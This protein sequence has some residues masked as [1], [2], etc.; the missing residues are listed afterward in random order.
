MR[1]H[2]RLKCQGA[3]VGGNHRG[4]LFQSEVHW[5]F[6]TS[7]HADL[8]HSPRIE[9]GQTLDEPDDRAPKVSTRDPHERPGELKAVRIRKVI[10]DVLR[11]LGIRGVGNRRLWKRWLLEKEI[12]RHEKQFGEKL[13]SICGHP[14]RTVFVSLNEPQGNPERVGDVGLRHLKPDPSLPKA[15]PDEA[16]DRIDST[17]MQML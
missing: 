5:R 12:D 8:R 7:D 4:E 2:R 10:K 16:V 3:K 1:L 15:F 11:D 13:Q 6:G 9:P 17:A 14:A